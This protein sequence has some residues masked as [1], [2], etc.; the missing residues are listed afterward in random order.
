MIAV[1]SGLLLR[2]A[3]RLQHVLNTGIGPQG[4]EN[5]FLPGPRRFELM[6]IGRLV[7]EYRDSGREMLMSAFASD[8][9]YAPDVQEHDARMRRKRRFQA[10]AFSARA[11]RRARSGDDLYCSEHVE[12]LTPS[13]ADR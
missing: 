3:I 8:G 2:P 10:P 11:V 9:P 7:D 5:L 4:E 13:S 1:G 12:I 6:R